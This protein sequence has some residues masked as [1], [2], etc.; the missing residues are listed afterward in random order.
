MFQSVLSPLPFLSRLFH[1][2]PALPCSQL[3]SSE[4]Q[5]KC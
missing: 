3:S 4:C 5:E 2:S 1:V